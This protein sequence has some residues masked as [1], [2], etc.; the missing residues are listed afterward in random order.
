MFTLSIRF[1]A[2]TYR[3][4]PWTPAEEAP[5]FE[6]PPAPWRLL[7][8]LSAAAEQQGVLETAWPILQPLREPPIYHLPPAAVGFPRAGTTNRPVGFVSLSP[9]GS[10]AYAS[11]PLVHL[12]DKERAVLSNLLG[13]ITYLG[14]SDVPVSMAVAPG[15]PADLFLYPCATALG[16]LPADEIALLAA[17]P[18]TDP[19]ALHTR[20]PPEGVPRTA[21]LVH[22]FRPKAAIVGRLGPSALPSP[23][24]TLYRYGVA[25]RLPLALGYALA[26]QVRRAAMSLYGQQNRGSVSALLSGKDPVTGSPSPDHRHAH[27]LP[28]DEDGDGFVDHLTVYTAA[29]LGSLELQALTALR[30]VYPTASLTKRVHLAATDDLPSL[31]GPAATWVSHLPFAPVRHAKQMHG[32]VQN[33]PRDQ[34]LLELSRRGQPTPINVRLLHTR[35]PKEFERLAGPHL[36]QGPRYFAE[37]TFPQPIS[38]PIAIGAASHFGMGLFLPSDRLK[39]GGHDTSI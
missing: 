32:H 36:S 33:G 12:E 37:I 4:I 25:D 11:W 20:R 6:W 38:G 21:M 26:E 10:T 27:F 5:L 2:A 9:A 17:G 29:G 19:K 39:E 34:I 24:A 14:H 22:Y 13:H 30:V 15:L 1:L 8:A 23:D 16:P 3:A 18:D 7:R 28:T 31:L 35:D